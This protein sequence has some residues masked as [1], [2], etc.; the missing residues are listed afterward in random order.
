MNIQLR[1]SAMK[2]AV[3][4]VPLTIVFLLFSAISAYRMWHFR[5]IYRESTV[6]RFT[7]Y[8]EDFEIV[9]N[10]ILENFD[11]KEP[12]DLLVDIDLNTGEFQSLSGGGVSYYPEQR[13][14][15]AFTRMS[16]SLGGYTLTYIF[17]SQSQI[18][19]AGFTERV[20]AFTKNGKR[21]RF[22]YHKGD[23]MSFHTYPLWDDWYYLSF[24]IKIF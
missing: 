17:I 13:V 4:L 3:I 1:S 16:D 6:E 20:I 23:G 21:P 14:C 9:N 15:D 24:A 10:Y 8:R 7:P 22:F 12:T 19:Y 18:S 11:V 5:P 2:K